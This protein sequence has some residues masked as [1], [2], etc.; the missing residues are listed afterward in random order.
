MDDN[1]DTRTFLPISRK[2]TTPESEYFTSR[3]RQSARIGR[4]LD[5]LTG[6]TYS[7]SIKEIFI[8]SIKRFNSPVKDTDF[9]VV[10]GPDIKKYYQESENDYAEG[11]NTLFDSCMRGKPVSFFDFY[12]ENPNCSLLIFNN[13]GQDKVMARALVWDNPIIDGAITKTKIMD[14]VYFTS[15]YQAGIFH[16]YA[17][18]NKWYFRIEKTIHNEIG[19]S[20]YTGTVTTPNIIIPIKKYVFDEYPYLDTFC[21]IVYSGPKVEKYGA[22]VTNRIPTN[23]EYLESRSQTFDGTVIKK[24]TL[25]SSEYDLE[26]AHGKNIQVYW[27]ILKIYTKGKYYIIKADI[28]DLGER[29]GRELYFLWENTNNGTIMDV[30]DSDLISIKRPKNTKRIHLSEKQVNEIPPILL[31]AAKDSWIGSDY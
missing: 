6:K 22:Y 18:K 29:Y 2:D 1:E 30:D 16:A 17:I 11:K 19:I 15:E 21:D 24:N 23:S 12:A 5:M 9:F 3:N 26:D 31:E 25:V 13:R 14:R 10:T 28:M 20:S 27:K 4:K 7:S 8:K